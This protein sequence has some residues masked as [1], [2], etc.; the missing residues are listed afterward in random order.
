MDYA[1]GYPLRS[2]GSVTPHQLRLLARRAEG[3]HFATFAMPRAD[4]YTSLVLHNK[5]VEK[6]SVASS[7]LATHSNRY[8]PTLN[9][10]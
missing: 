9:A 6:V 4:S 2:R 3:R 10:R 7:P 8:N 5:T 1:E